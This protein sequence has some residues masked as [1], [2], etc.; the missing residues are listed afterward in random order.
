KYADK[1]EAATVLAKENE[2]LIWLILNNITRVKR[3]QYNL[4]VLLSLAYLEQYTIQTVLDL[5]KIEDYLIEAAKQEAKPMR[6]MNALIRSRRLADKIMED[7][8]IMWKNFKAVWERSQFPR[9]RTVNGKSF[10]NIMPDVNGG[11][12]INRFTGLEYMIA[13][14]ERIGLKK[15]RDGIDK[16]ISDFAKRHNLDIEE[17]DLD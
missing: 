6:A 9:N 4:E 1:I 10:V 17:K 16:V 12:D 8:D 3:N 15:W 2:R 5:A 14:F 11:G 7:Q 13:P